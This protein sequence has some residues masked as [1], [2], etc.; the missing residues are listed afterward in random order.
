MCYN[1]VQSGINWQYVCKQTSPFV[2]CSSCSQT[3]QTRLYCVLSALLFSP[4]TFKTKFQVLKELATCFY[5]VL[6]VRSSFSVSSTHLEYVS[7]VLTK[8]TPSA[9]QLYKLWY[10]YGLF[11]HWF[12]ILSQDFWL[13]TSVPDQDFQRFVPRTMDNF[14]ALNMLN[15]GFMQFVFDLT[16]ADLVRHVFLALLFFG[17]MM[18]TRMQWSAQLEVMNANEDWQERAGFL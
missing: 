14:A 2:A 9:V 10:K 13:C 6:K 16:V 17:G 8:S 7:V 18:L 4:D 5:M 11:P 1:V 12:I 3:D 15:V